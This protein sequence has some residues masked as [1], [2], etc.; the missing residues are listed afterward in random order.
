[1]C[2]ARLLETDSDVTRNAINVW[3]HVLYCQ[4]ELRS[5]ISIEG[6]EGVHTTI[7]MN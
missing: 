1:M 6:N 3:R 4:K 5:S 7:N 2:S